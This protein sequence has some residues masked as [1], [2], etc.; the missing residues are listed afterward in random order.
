MISRLLLTILILLS[1]STGV[2]AQDGILVEEGLSEPQIKEIKDWLKDDSKWVKDDK[3]FQTAWIRGARKRNVRPRPAPPE[4]LSDR[5]AG[6]TIG[7]VIIMEACQKLKEARSDPGVSEIRDKVVEQIQQHEAPTT[8]TFF[9]RIHFGGGWIMVR[10]LKSFR[11]GAIFETHFSIFTKGRFEVNSPGLTLLTEIN[12]ERKR[13]TKF[14]P[15][16]GVSVRVREFEAPG[17]NGERWILYWNMVNV[18]QMTSLGPQRS[19]LAG[20]SIAKAPPPKRRAP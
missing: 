18:W 3:R 10:D 19:G 12:E 14:A 7:P 17:R 16:F 11:N 5:C 2:E 9:E 13:I 20:F 15:D 4:W 6:L 1:S 8:K